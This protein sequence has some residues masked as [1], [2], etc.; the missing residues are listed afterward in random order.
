[1]YVCVNNS[2]PSLNKLQLSINFLHVSYIRLHHVS[3]VQLT[4]DHESVRRIYR[5]QLKHPRGIIQTAHN[6]MNSAKD[7]VCP[8]FLSTHMWNAWGSFTDGVVVVGGRCRGGR[9][10]SGTPAT[11]Y[12][13]RLWSVSPLV[14]FVISFLLWQSWP[15]W[16]RYSD[17]THISFTCLVKYSRAPPL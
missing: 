6:V 5:P 7:V 8:M 13:Q 16:A 4:S 10:G 15:M 1:M 12:H 2:N 11:Y 9:Q 14:S 3:P 17:L